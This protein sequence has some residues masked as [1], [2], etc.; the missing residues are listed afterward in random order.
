MLHH[1][2]LTSQ[3]TQNTVNFKT[4]LTTDYVQP[5]VSKKKKKVGLSKFNSCLSFGLGT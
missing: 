2:Y 4:I 3:C 1:Q 5:W